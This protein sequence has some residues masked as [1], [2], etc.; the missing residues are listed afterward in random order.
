MERVNLKAEI[1]RHKVQVKDIAA[2]IGISERT[3][4]NKLNGVTDF[5]WGQA[6]RIQ[7]EFFPE[8][9]KDYLFD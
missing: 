9:S 5:T 6:C 8:L 1:T 7:K 2:S 3:M 4:K